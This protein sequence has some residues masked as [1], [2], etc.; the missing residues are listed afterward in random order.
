MGSSVLKMEEGYKKGLG[1][2]RTYKKG[3]VVLRSSFRG[4][5]AARSTFPHSCCEAS[6]HVC[7]GVQSAHELDIHKLLV[8]LLNQ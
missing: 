4:H 7:G 3:L 2:L 1:V 6:A 5:A 8:I